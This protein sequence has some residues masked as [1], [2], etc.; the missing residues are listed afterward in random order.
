MGESRVKAGSVKKRIG[1]KA[2]KKKPGAGPGFSVFDAAAA[3]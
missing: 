2:G 3:Q 1:E